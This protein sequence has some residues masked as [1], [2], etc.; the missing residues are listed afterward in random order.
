MQDSTWQRLPRAILRIQIKERLLRVFR[1]S[2]YLVRCG[3]EF[4]IVAR[5]TIA[6]ED[7]VLPDGTRL[8]MTCSIG[9]ASHPFIGS[10][11][12]ALSWQEVVEMIDMALHAAKRAGR[13]A[14]VGIGATELTRAPEL[15]AHLK[16]SP[17]EAVHSGTVVLETNLDPAGVVNVL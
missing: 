14:W 6:N 8:A 7:F 2:D 9:Y 15:R 17:C 12:L 5:A 3:E 11:P 16:S 10:D 13:D 4:L 1:E